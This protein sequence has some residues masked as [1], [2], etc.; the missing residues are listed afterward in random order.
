VRKRR[1]IAHTVI[2]LLSVFLL[3]AACR[4]GGNTEHAPSPPPATPSPAPAATQIPD[5][6]T[7]S[8]AE[9][10]IPGRDLMDLARRYRGLPADAPRVARDTPLNHSVG[11]VETFNVIDLTIPRQTAV[12]A[13]VRY[14]SEHAYFF[15]ENG[16]TYTDAALAQV[17]RDFDNLVHP[18]VRDFFG[19]EWT[20]GVDGDERITIL[21]AG[22]RGAAGYFSSS[23]EYPRSAVPRSNEREMLYLS[24]GIL[25][26]PG[27]AYNALVA[28]ELQHLVHWNGNPGRDSWVNE[29]LAQIAAQVV[30][31]GRGW[32]GLFLAQPD[33]P[34]TFWPEIEA[35]AVHYAAAELFFSYLFDHYGPR[36]RAHELVSIPS[37]GIAG[38]D[39]YLA[40]FGTDFREVFAGWTVAN[41][42]DQREGP[43]GHRTLEVSITNTIQAPAGGGGTVGQFGTDYLTLG[44]DA[45]GA[46][47]SFEGDTEVSIGVP[48]LDGPF[49][50]SNRGDSINPR[51]T[52]V[53][54]LT[55][56]ESA[57][58][59]FSAWFEIEDGWDYAYVAVSSD[60]GETW[61]ALPGRHT[62]DFDPVGSAYGPGYTGRSDG[63]VEEQ[64]DLSAYAGQ[65]VLLRFEYV[66]DDAVS[67]TGMAVDNIRIPETGF[68]DGAGSAAGWDAEGFRRMAGPLPQE[69]IVHHIELGPSP[70]VHRIELDTGNRASFGISGPSV[71]VVSGATEWTAEAAG[72][73]W[74]VR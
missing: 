72:Y 16:A 58:L 34:L 67:F 62:T 9:T 40:P 61:R 52:R 50:W 71:V 53:L 6:A 19:S 36:D 22:L 21:H 47:F 33:T 8:D 29:G 51:L 44:D 14:V 28:H 73:R 25:S 20:P 68:S 60:D 15:V 2:A 63:W 11:D 46:T 3:A 48:Q 42:L 55:G 49:W 27:T 74:R 64:I 17:A 39:E 59:Q 56:V 10:E 1:A 4:G 41:Y 65:E 69:F 24:A 13:T 18:T 30:A 23:D 26:S 7:L 70:A 12:T 35:S 38:V 57:T 5:P 32:A 43:Y 66:T 31:N 54:D 45:A 37:D